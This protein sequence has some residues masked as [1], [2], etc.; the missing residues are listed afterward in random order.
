MILIYVQMRDEMLKTHPEFTLLWAIIW[1][2]AENMHGLW[3]RT[4]LVSELLA[5]GPGRVS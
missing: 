5:L 3:A 1:E 4:S 2:V